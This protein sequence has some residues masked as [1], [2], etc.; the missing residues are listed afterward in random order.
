M[1][2]AGPGDGKTVTVLDLGRAAKREGRKVRLVDA[3][4]RTPELSRLCRDGEEFT[5]SGLGG[6]GEDD[7]RGRRRRLPEPRLTTGPRA[8]RAPPSR[9]F[10]SAAFGEM[11]SARTRPTSS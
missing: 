2:S 4:E 7:A 3:D 9:L 5:V 10:R 8:E 11:I 6:D 1:V